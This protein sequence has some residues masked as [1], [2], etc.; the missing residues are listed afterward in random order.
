MRK[1]HLRHAQ[2]SVRLFLQPFGKTE[3]AADHEAQT[4]PPRSLTGFQQAGEGRAV[5]LGPFHAEADQKS[6]TE[7][8][9]FD[10]FALAQQRIFNFSRFRF[11]AEAFLRKLDHLEAAERT[12]PFFVFRQGIGIEA[13][14][15]SA[16][17]DDP[18]VQHQETE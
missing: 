17:T 6:V 7:K 4:R 8:L 5:H 14:F 3:G 10:S 16:D 9:F 13:F 11:F 15:E 12:Q 2:A 18:D 1:G